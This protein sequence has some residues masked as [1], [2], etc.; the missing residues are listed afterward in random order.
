MSKHLILGLL[1]F[2]LSILIMV[3]YIAAVLVPGVL[4]FVFGMS[5]ERL[6][7]A[8]VF[9]PVFLLMIGFSVGI[10]YVAYSI[11]LEARENKGKGQ[12]EEAGR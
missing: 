4:A 1:L 7:F 6:Q 12:R 5:V 3:I 9:I 10:A 11:V 8:L 2:I